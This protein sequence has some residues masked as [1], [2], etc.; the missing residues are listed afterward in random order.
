MG[1]NRFR[2]MTTQSEESIQGESAR[3]L[4]AAFSMETDGDE[5]ESA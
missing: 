5:K 4:T 1:K 3:Q 2:E